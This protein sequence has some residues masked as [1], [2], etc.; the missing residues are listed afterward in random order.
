MKKNNDHGTNDPATSA[1]EPQYLIHTIQ[2]STTAEDAQHHG[3]TNIEQAACIPIIN[4]YNNYYYRIRPARRRLR[5][6]SQPLTPRER[7]LRMMTNPPVARIRRLPP[8][9][10]S[11]AAP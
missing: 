4:N 7:L 2:T 10:E 9:D 5:R 6:I 11:D 1:G 3:S 8:S